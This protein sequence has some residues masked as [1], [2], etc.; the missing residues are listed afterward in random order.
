VWSLGVNLYELL[1]GRPPFRAAG[2]RET[3]SL[4]VHAD[5]IPPSHLQPSVP[6]DLDTI[7]LKCL[8]K[9]PL[10]RYSGARELAQDL[11]CFLSGEA[12]HARPAGPLER[13]MK[14][15]RRHP[16]LAVLTVFMLLM[17]LVGVV[18]TVAALVHLLRPT[19]GR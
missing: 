11:R 17:A 5:P 13:V 6:R 18:A 16:V 19:P 10:R 7:C 9:D 14:W 1:T 4:V 12:I 15:T 3:L 8:Q 2:T